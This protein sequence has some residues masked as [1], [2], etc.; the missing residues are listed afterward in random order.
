MRRVALPGPDA[1]TSLPAHGGGPMEEASGRGGGHQGG[2]LGAAAGLT[3]DHHLVWIAAETGDVVPH[4]LQRQ[5]KVELS[6]VAAV[7]Q[8]GDQPGEVGVT[9][10]VEP[11]VQRHHHHVAA[12]A[13]P[14]AI[15]QRRRA[16]AV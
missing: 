2:D 3:E 10:G 16:R 6:G 15:V 8:F 12:L 11:V 13:E 9:E 5:D 4:P 7:G 1:V 14:H